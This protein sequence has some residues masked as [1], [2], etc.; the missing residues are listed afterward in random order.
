MSTDL[1]VIKGGKDGL[2]VQ[3]D[4]QAEWPAVLDALRAHLS[5][6]GAFLQ[7]AKLLLDVGLR[8]VSEQELEDALALMRGHGLRPDSVASLTREGRQA[9]RA[10]GLNSRALARTNEATAQTAEQAVC[11]RRTVRSGQIIR[12]PG[13]IT[14]IGD[15]NAGGEIIAGGSVIVWGRVRGVVHAGAMGDS[16]AVICALE[17]TPTQLRIADRIARSPE[18]G[19]QRFPEIAHIVGEHI[20]VEVW[21]TFRR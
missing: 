10:A 21:H 17:L 6:G 20:L 18:G 14:I 15:V 11:M 16:S 9:A 1:V 12:H 8:Q 19:G 13:D 2:R 7:G 5:Q 4:E 3:L